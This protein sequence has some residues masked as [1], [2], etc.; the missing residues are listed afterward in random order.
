[1]RPVSRNQRTLT[2]RTG[3]CQELFGE[4]E[5]WLLTQTRVQQE[6]H[7]RLKGARRGRR[8][9]IF[10]RHIHRQ[11]L[12]TYFRNALSFNDR[13]ADISFVFMDFW[14]ISATFVGF[15]RLFAGR[16]AA[17]RNQGTEALRVADFATKLALRCVLETRRARPKVLD[18]CFVPRRQLCACV[19]KSVDFSIS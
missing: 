8:A 18:C 15:R 10:I 13:L 7:E 11:R 19:S 3:I 14:Q 6:A 16:T 17:I 9:R 12:I 4:T 1:V 5:I 2:G